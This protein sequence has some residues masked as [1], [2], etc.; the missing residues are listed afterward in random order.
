M[1]QLAHFV[2]FL[3]LLKPRVVIYVLIAAAAYR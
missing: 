2:G 3:M 1:V